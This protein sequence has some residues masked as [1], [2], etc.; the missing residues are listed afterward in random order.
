[1]KKLLTLV[2]SLMLAAALL[3]PGY[4][5]GEGDKPLIGILQFV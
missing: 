5:F 4:A 2:V 1:M 3:V